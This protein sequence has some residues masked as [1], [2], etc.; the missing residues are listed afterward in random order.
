[1]AIKLGQVVTNHE[2]LPLIKLHDF[3]MTCFG[4]SHDKLITL[5]LLLH[6]INEHRGT[7]MTYHEGLPSIKSHTSL[8]TIHG[9]IR[10]RDKLKL[11]YLHY[12]KTFGHQNCQGSCHTARS[13]HS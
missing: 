5:Y 10:S 13:S 11:S 4:M 6:Q 2:K 3:S 12:H 9:Y 8:H 7:P 1:M